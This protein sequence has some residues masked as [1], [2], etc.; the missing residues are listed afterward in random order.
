LIYVFY[1]ADFETSIDIMRF[2]VLGSVF[3]VASWPIGFVVLAKGHSLLFLISD[4]SFYVIF[5]GLT[6]MYLSHM[7]LIITGIAYGAAYLFQAILVHFVAYRLNGYVPTKKNVF[8]ISLQA[9][10]VMILLYTST[11]SL[12]AS[13][14][15]GSLMMLATATYCFVEI[16]RITDHAIPRFFK[17]YIGRYSK[18]FIDRD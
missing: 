2:Q 1:T 12:I 3:R 16:N 15:L 14:V 10:F 4:L 18:L 13:Y 8:Y 9:C 17:Q 11:K 5:F 6:F 7:G